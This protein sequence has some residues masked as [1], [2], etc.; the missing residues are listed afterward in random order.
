MCSDLQSAGGEV[1]WGD[2]RCFPGIHLKEVKNNKNFN[3]DA[4]SPNVA[5]CGYLIQDVPGSNLGP[6]TGYPD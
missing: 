6:K 3:W 4:D 1:S 2:A 5:P